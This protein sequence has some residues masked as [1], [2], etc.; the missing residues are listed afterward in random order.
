MSNLVKH[1]DHEA[2][3]EVLEDLMTVPHDVSYE[4]HSDRSVT[5]TVNAF[6]KT[7]RP[8]QTTSDV[9]QWYAA[10]LHASKK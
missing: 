4:F 3:A 2:M 5:L 1:H 8:E 9:R 10:A 7:F 6:R